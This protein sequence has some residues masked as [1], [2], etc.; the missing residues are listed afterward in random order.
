MNRQATRAKR[1]H[2]RRNENVELKLRRERDD[3]KPYNQFQNQVEEEKCLIVEAKGA[4]G[5][6]SRTGTDS[7]QPDPDAVSRCLE[8]E[9]QAIETVKQRWIE[10]GIWD[11]KWAKDLDFLNAKWKHEV[12]PVSQPEPHASDDK[13]PGCFK[14]LFQRKKPQPQLQPRP[15]SAQDQ[16]TVCNREASRPSPQFSYQI[17]LQTRRILAQGNNAVTFS[18]EQVYDR[19]Y[20]T[21]KNNWLEWGIWNETWG[22]WPGPCW[23]HEEPFD[24]DITDRISET[25]SLGRRRHRVSASKNV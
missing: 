1:H 20:Q 15:L 9:K 4:G 22:N 14:S 7:E 18:P 24:G 8:Y 11:E 12:A 17:A 2:K 23:Q 19:A 3:S 25:V 13:K 5:K 6:L 16:K 21:V 10:Q